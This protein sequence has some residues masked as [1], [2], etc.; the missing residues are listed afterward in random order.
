MVPACI[1]HLMT[2]PPWLLL[3]SSLGFLSLLTHTLSLLK[4]IFAKFLRP[5]K[6][7]KHYGS[8]ALITGASDGIGKAFAHQLALQGLN[9]ILV[10][11]NPQKLESVSTEILAQSPITKIKIVTFDFCGDI[12]KGVRLIEEAIEGLDVGVL[13][14]NVG[15]TYPAARFFHEVEERVWMDIVR[16]NLEGTTRVTK[17][18]M[19]GMIKRRSGAVVNVGSGAA[20]V[21]PSHPLYAIYAATKAFVDQLS[22]SLHVEYKGCGIHVQCQVPLYVATNMASK[23]ALIEKSTLF[24]PSANDYVQA[25][26]CHIG[27][28]P[29]CTPYWAHSIQWCLARLLVPDDVL[30]A[31]RFYIGVNRRGKPKFE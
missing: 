17:A 1:N 2:Q 21:V 20:I 28:E 13:I 27:Y 11:R 15:I 19:P 31:W 18:V 22:R 5:S 7:L 29:R 16:V 25:A 26:I 10:G 6:N 24:I 12:S 23:A 4:W 8:W 3:V 9:L 14:N 30:D